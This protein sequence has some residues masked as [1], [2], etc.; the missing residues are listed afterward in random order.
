M[1]LKYIFKTILKHKD[2]TDDPRMEKASQGTTPKVGSVKEI[3][4]LF[5]LK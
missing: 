3:I 1:L 2:N 4:H 5:T